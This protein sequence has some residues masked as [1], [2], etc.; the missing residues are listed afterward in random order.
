LPNRHPNWRKDQ[1][2]ETVRVVVVYY[3]DKPERVKSAFLF[4]KFNKI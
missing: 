4:D 1:V 3:A 2:K